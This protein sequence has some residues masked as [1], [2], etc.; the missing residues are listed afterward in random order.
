MSEATDGEDVISDNENDDDLADDSV[1]DL[2]DSFI[3]VGYAISYFSA[4]FY[5]VPII[6]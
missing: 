2:E 6:C 3:D 4:F 5:L 1:Y